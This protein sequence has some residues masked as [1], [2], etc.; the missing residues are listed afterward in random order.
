MSQRPEGDPGQQSWSGV[1]QPDPRMTPRPPAP[2]Q[3]YRPDAPS[4]HG[5]GCGGQPGYA[6]QPGYPPQ[7]YAPQQYAPAP[8]PPRPGSSGPGSPVLGYVALGV[9]VLATLSSLAGGWLTIQ[10]VVSLLAGSEYTGQPDRGDLEQAL[11]GPISVV[12]ASS[13]LGF[14]GWVAGIVAAATD[15]GRVAGI[16]AIVVGVIAPVLIWGYIGLSFAMLIHD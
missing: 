14:A 1:P 16:V 2:G 9:V 15:R 7:P 10:D 11:I 12:G 3:G 4:Q 13:T 8:Y 6:P 5:Y